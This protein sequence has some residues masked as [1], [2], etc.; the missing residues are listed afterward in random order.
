MSTQSHRDKV[1]LKAN[2]LPFGHH[3]GAPKIQPLDLTPFKNTGVKKSNDSFT[4]KYKELLRQA[5]ILQESFILNQEVYNS[6]YNFEPIVGEI[7]HLYENSRAEKFLSII[8]PTE[9]N[10]KYLYSVQ[11]NSELIWEKFDFKKNN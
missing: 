8:K 6:K 2:I 9:W 4:T 11:L 5:E 10:Q 3:V 7:Y 1:E